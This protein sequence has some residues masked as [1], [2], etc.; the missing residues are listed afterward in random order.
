MEQDTTI[1]HTPATIEISGPRST[2]REDREPWAPLI[3]PTNANP[4][5]SS[6]LTPQK[7]LKD[8]MGSATIAI[9]S[10]TTT[11]PAITAAATSGTGSGGTGGG[12]APSG[13]A[14]NLDAQDIRDAFDAALCRTG[15]EQMR[16]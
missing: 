4:S 16:S 7:Q 6:P 8:T 5:Y 12:T 10:T 1:R 11:T 2:H 9:T 14:P 15:P 13:G 3:T